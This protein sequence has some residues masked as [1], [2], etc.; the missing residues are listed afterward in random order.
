MT[1]AALR[2]RMDRLRTSYW[3]LPVLGGLVAV[4]A[5][6]L[7][8]LIDAR[9]PN[10][11]LEGKRFILNA[12]LDQA[13][14]MMTTLAGTILATTGIV[15]SLL[16][17]P[18]SLAASQFGSRLL[19]LYIRDGTI[20]SILAVFAG[21]FVYCLTLALALPANETEGSTPQL[22]VTF[23]LSLSLVAFGSLLILIQHIASAL[24]APN[25]IRAASDELKGVIASVLDGEQGDRPVTQRVE[26]ESLMATLETERFPIHAAKQGYV[27]AV[28]VEI[29][30]LMATRY[31]LLLQL[32]RSPG[33]FVRAGDLI[34]LAYPAGNV[35]AQAAANIADAYR[36][37]SVRIP[38]QDL[39][40]GVFQL[41]EI[42]VRAMSLA[43]N[44]PYT[45]ITCLD[46]LGGRLS[47]L[48]ARPMPSSIIYDAGGQVRLLTDDYSLADLLRAAFD[49]LRHA[50]RDTANVLLAMLDAIEEI[51]RSAY[52]AE[53]RAELAHHVALIRA[54]SNAGSSIAWDKER[55]DR[56][57]DDVLANLAGGNS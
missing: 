56:R 54:E 32:V 21:A 51:G 57:C 52:S 27:Q 50:S 22:A 19:R 25:L 7:L 35:P 28:D 33:H 8:L 48:A 31:D 1:R 30:L 3:F 36:L 43:I 41:A 16:T 26:T 18:L 37:G 42:A 9:I 53:Y 45:A 12:S 34:A 55:V 23:G 24:Q 20:Q 44:D 29:A 47:A 5:T 6:Y 38:S 40:Y 49:I 2:Q 39:E 14:T 4:A 13:R 10:E 11:L 17:V 46:H 15:F